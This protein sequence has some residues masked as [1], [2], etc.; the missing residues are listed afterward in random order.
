[1]QMSGTNLHEWQRAKL[2]GMVGELASNLHPPN[3]PQHARPL[4]F[5]LG[6]GTERRAV[7]PMTAPRSADRDQWLMKG[8]G[9]PPH[10][11]HSLHP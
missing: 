7:M 6:R 9:A 2:P 11:S 4:F 8:S 1:M 3:Q 5:I 10:I